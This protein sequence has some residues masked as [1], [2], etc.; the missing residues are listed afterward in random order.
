MIT[1]FG[2]THAG[3]KV[4]QITL[5][6]G[7]LTATFL[8]YG[9]VLQDLRL[10][11]HPP[12]LVLGLNSI[13][14]YQTHSPYFGAT[15]GR[16][17]NRI[18]GG[19]FTLD[20]Q[21]HAVDRNFLG[22]HLLH[23]GADG[24]GKRLWT[25]GE[26]SDSHVVLQISLPHGHMGFPGR[27]DI[28]ARFSLLSGGGL[29]IVYEAQTDAPTLCN[30]AH[31][32]YFNLTGGPDLSGHIL[33]VAA[34]RMTEVDAELIPTGRSLD[35]S[36]TPYDLREGADLGAW[37][38]GMLL[39]HNFCLS[40]ARGALGQVASLRAGALEMALHTT[41]PG[42]QVYDGAKV[43]VPVPGLDGARYG[44]YAGIALE[45]QVWPDAINQAGF[46]SAILRPGETYRQHSR[47]VFVL[48]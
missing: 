10:D 40:Q 34:D 14:D 44:A 26:R 1:T 39:D 30:I 6:G 11:G 31:H 37:P 47:Y 36:G 42:L 24:I 19:Q 48:S 2:Q 33:R 27:L 8:T 20:G 23:G 15:A 41:E 43:A 28:S 7:G 35:V 17:A 32:S 46:P 38:Q 45:P 3:E 18:G 9:A 13:E 5:K 29:D 22:K 4:E 25:I 12:P 16:C 21:T